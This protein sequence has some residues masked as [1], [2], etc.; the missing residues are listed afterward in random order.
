MNMDLDRSAMFFLSLLTSASEYHHQSGGISC[1]GL[2]PLKVI[3][4]FKNID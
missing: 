4:L 3:Y 2:E 1:S